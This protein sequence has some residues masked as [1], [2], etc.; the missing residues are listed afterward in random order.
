MDIQNLNQALSVLVEKNNELNALDYNDDNY[1]R[2]EEELHDLEDDFLDTYG[3][4]LDDVLRDVHDEYCPD[5]DVLLAI[6][7]LAKK[8]QKVDKNEDGSDRYEVGPNEGVLV[9]ADEY[10]N[11]VSKLVLIPGPTRLVLNIRNKDQKVV[12]TAK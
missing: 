1:D 12:W 3:D 10:P 9:D 7:Y 6:A 8:Y 2:V 5:S 4:F 11:Q